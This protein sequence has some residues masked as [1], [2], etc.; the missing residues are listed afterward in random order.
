MAEMKVDGQAMWVFTGAEVDQLRTGLFRDM[1]ISGVEDVEA[2]TTTF[3]LCK[4]EAR[5]GVGLYS[6]AGGRAVWYLCHLLRDRATWQR[7][8][9]I[10]VRCTSCDFIGEGADPFNVDMYLGVP[11][12]AA[13]RARLK[14]LRRIECPRCGA[15]LSAFVIWVTVADLGRIPYPG[16][17]PQ[18]P[19]ANPPDGK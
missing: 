1:P 2:W 12:P 11:D 8:L 3:D 13:T 5:L 15:R 16:P 18:W 6:M 9:F 4:S 14:G 10:P 17:E 19:I 7:F